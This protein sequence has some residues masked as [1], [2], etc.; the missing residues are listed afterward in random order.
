[1]AG[2]PHCQR[3]PRRSPPSSVGQSLSPRRTS[4]RT[5]KHERRRQPGLG[6]GV[7]NVR[8]RINIRGS[9]QE[10]GDARLICGGPHQH[11][12]RAP[13][14]A[15]EQHPLGGRSPSTSN[16]HHCVRGHSIAS[17]SVHFAPPALPVMSSQLVSRDAECDASHRPDAPMYSMANFRSP[18]VI[19]GLRR[20]QPVEPP[21][22]PRASLIQR[23]RPSGPA[24]EGQPLRS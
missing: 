14:R 1:V 17:K 20:P 23:L 10:E 12:L 11:R 4:S 6:L 13:R 24:P 19:P 18:A 16:A 15:V 3:P 8:C 5:L 22:H 21:G 9:E 7:A 2:I